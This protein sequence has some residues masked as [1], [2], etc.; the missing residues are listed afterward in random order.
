MGCFGR[1]AHF[2]DRS[3]NYGRTGTSSRIENYLGFPTGISG[4]DLAR[5]AYTQATRLGAEIITAQE[6]KIIS[7]KDPYKI[8]TLANGTEVVCHALIIATGVLLNQLNIPDMERLTE[9]GVNYGAASI[10]AIYY[11]DEHIYVVGGANSAG[12]GA[13]FFSRYAKQVTMLVRSELSKSMSQYLFNHIKGIPN[14]EVLQNTE[15][16][17]VHS[18]D[19]L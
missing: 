16:V 18:K 10:E 2:I 11:K 1:F 4:A 19:K 9:A 6:V 15:V 5:R 13:I 7:I 17:E 14:I 8:V 3:R 12:Q